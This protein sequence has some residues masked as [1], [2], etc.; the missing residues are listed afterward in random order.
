MKKLL[1]AFILFTSIS[2]Y[3][4]SDENMKK[5]AAVK[6]EI[7]LITQKDNN[8]FWNI[9]YETPL[10]FVNPEN[11][12]AYVFDIGTEPYKLILDDNILIANT[13]LKWKEKMWAMVQTPL[14]ENPFAKEILILHEM[15][16]ALQP[17]L[18][19]GDIYENT[20]SHLEQKEARILLR[21]EL[22]AL[23]EALVTGVSYN[24]ID[25]IL[26][27]LTNALTF[28]NF[29]QSLYP[30]AKEKENYLELNEGLAEYTALML[31]QNYSE[32]KQKFL[33][34]YFHNRI[35]KF[36]EHDSYVRFFAY[37]TIPL[38]GYLMQY[39]IPNWHLKINV[40]TNL[41]DF[42]IKETNIKCHEEWKDLI[43]LYDN[44]IQVI[45]KQE[46]ERVEQISDVA[47][48]VIEKFKGA[49]HVEIPL[50]QYSYNFDPMNIMVL[51]SIGELHVNAIFTD[52]WGKLE[53]S[54]G[55]I[56]D[57]ENMKLFL[58]PATQIKG[59]T[60]TGDGWMLILNKG[61]K[62]NQENKIEK[63]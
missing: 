34:S 2:L 30:E 53:V 29:R 36:L 1:L 41:T 12:Q 58:S 15:F 16:H 13:A 39:F 6:S 27:H 18:G 49:N 26:F 17:Q 62:I 43:P 48:K 46:D 52:N 38:Y 60:I 22:K 35:S 51:E 11:K 57:K 59:N 61:W 56:L 5:L 45:I 20:C 3:A 25:S 47:N 21:L 37:E 54:K 24:S 32:N 7:Q 8:S 9:P 19:F 63:K 31:I 4:Q 28:R 23:S 44:N 10:L 42:F 50:F 33:A 14:P 40:N 55:L